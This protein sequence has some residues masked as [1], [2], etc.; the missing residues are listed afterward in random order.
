VHQE[1]DQ[2]KRRSGWP[3]KRSLA[4]LGIAQRSYYRWLKSDNGSDYIS[5]EFRMVLSE[6]GLVH[7]RI[8]PHC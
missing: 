8:Q 7:R 2:S 4:A 3:V 5:T 6:N 1:V